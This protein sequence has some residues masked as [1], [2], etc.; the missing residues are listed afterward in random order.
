MKT[1][2]DIELMLFR[3][4]EGLLSKDESREATLFLQQHPEWQAV[5]DLY[6]PQLKVPPYPA[7]GFGDKESLRKPLTVAATAPRRVPALR[8]IS[9][10]ASIIIAAS[11][12]AWMLLVPKAEKDGPVIVAENRQ[13]RDN[14][15]FS[16]NTSPS[17]IRND[18]ASAS[19]E[20]HKRSLQAAAPAVTAQPVQQEMHAAPVGQEAAEQM[21]TIR[22][23]TT[24][25]LIAYLDDA[26]SDE[27]ETPSI[28]MTDKLIAYLPT[29][30]S[31]TAPAESAPRPKWTYA[32]EDLWN[33]VQLAYTERQNEIIDIFTNKN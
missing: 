5:A 15:C 23:T 24:D 18:D 6:D 9:V 1:D 22:I 4:K 25:R 27:P 12:A 19:S 10:A 28:N 21:P 7:V 32:I 31:A 11:I 14:D 33:G 29:D 30:T 3:L 17:E 8:R 20:E 26:E 2:E 16:D 13:N